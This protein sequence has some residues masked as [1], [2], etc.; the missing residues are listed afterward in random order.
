MNSS[1]Y[2]FLLGST[3]CQVHIYSCRPGMLYASNYL[4]FLLRSSTKVLQL[5]GIICQFSHPSIIPYQQLITRRLMVKIIKSNLHD[6]LAYKET[7]LKQLQPMLF[8]SVS[9][10]FFSHHCT[11]EKSELFLEHTGRKSQFSKFLLP[12]MKLDL[13]L[14]GSQVKLPPTKLKKR[15]QTRSKIGYDFQWKR[16]K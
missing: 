3:K 13:S 4:V 7:D 6:W 14:K 15:K 5:S 11:A 8:Q 9:Q 10:K 2:G 1:M 16:N 12:L